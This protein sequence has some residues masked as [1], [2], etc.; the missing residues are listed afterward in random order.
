MGYIKQGEF[1]GQ[2]RR[3]PL[4]QNRGCFLFRMLTSTWAYQG[5]HTWADTLQETTTFDMNRIKAEHSK[6]RRNCP[7]PR[8]HSQGF[9][10]STQHMAMKSDPTQC[11]QLPARMKILGET[12][13]QL[14]SQCNKSLH[15]TTPSNRRYRRSGPSKRA[16]TNPQIL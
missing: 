4:L 9:Y 16:P 14:I 13:S 12:P 6:S 10:T 7:V 2:F 8:L 15:P 5:V 3:L 1:R 11:I